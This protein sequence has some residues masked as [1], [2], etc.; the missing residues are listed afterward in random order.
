MNNYLINFNYII[1]FI[2]FLIKLN[3]KKIILKIF[4][5]FFEN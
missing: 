5:Y 4:L 3:M 1:F 2:F